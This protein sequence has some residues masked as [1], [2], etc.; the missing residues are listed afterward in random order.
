MSWISR[1]RW[2]V[3]G[4]VAAVAIATAIVVVSRRRDGDDSGLELAQRACSEMQVILEQVSRDER[5]DR[6]RISLDSAVMSANRA[7]R[8]DPLWRPLAG[9][10]AAVRFAIDEDDAEAARVGL[11]VAAAQCER[12]GSPLQGADD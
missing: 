5:S 8:R 12:A 4:V 10:A 1:H 2:L 11:S 7:A 3:L 6:V 9:A